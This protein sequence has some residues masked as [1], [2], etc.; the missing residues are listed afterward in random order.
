[1]LLTTAGI[2]PIRVLICYEAIF[3][4]LVR[5]QHRPIA[6][7]QITNDA[8]FGTYSGPYQHLT[9]SRM[10]SIELG[11]PLMRAANTGISALV[12]SHGRITAHLSLGETGIID[13]ALPPP[14]SSTVYARL[15][16]TP[17][18]MTLLILLLLQT[19]QRV[20]NRERMRSG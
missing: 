2:G 18:H 4:G 8:W 3:P 14:V 1:T 17:L 19:L 12:D 5:Q 15:G 7:V 16:E 11:I 20:R 10:R 6:L 13:A 9:H